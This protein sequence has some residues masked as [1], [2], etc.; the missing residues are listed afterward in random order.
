MSIFTKDKNKRQKEIEKKCEEEFGYIIDQVYEYSRVKKWSHKTKQTDS[1]KNWLKKLIFEAQFNGGQASESVA[2]LNNIK[3]I[4]DNF[5]LNVEYHASEK[6]FK[7][8]GEKL[9]N[10]DMLKKKL[11]DS[12]LI[13][14]C[15]NYMVFYSDGHKKNYY[16]KDFMATYI[17]GHTITCFAFVKIDG[18]N[19][20]VFLD[21]NNRKKNNTS[22]RLKKTSKSYCYGPDKFYAT[23]SLLRF[24]KCVQNI[25]FLREDQV[26][27]LPKLVNE[28]TCE[29]DYL[30]LSNIDKDPKNNMVNVYDI[31]SV[32]KK[33]IIDSLKE[34]S[35]NEAAIKLKF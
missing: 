13:T 2:D 31:I 5:D 24:R 33:D 9:S 17:S 4:K 32:K 29:H 1:N 30:K 22:K 11:Q 35:L 12:V 6:N 23:K 34:L 21:T 27:D 16:F 15:M 10:S 8:L 7:E 3:N 25:V 26:L 18:V 28:N 14:S 19:Y 20:F